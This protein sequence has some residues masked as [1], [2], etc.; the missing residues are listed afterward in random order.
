[1]GCN[2]FDNPKPTAI[3]SLEFIIPQNI[4]S[5]CSVSLNTAV[6]AKFIFVAPMISQSD[7]FYIGY[8]LAHV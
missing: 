3:P 1:M 8:I 5:F 6:K 7:S 2:V 4:H